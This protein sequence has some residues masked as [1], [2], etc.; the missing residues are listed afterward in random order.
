MNSNLRIF[1]NTILVFILIFSASCSRNEDGGSSQSALPGSPVKITTPIKKNLTEYITLN[2]STFFLKKEIV[3]ATFQGFVEK[4]YKNIGDKISKGDLLLEIKTKESA[5]EDNLNI[6]LGNK[7]F[8]GLITLKAQSDGVLTELDYNTGDF[9]SDGEQIAVI[10]N[11]SSLRINLGV[12]YQYSNKI[13][14]STPCEII[15]P[16]GNIINASISKIIP[17]VDPVSQTQTFILQTSQ[18]V[19]LPENLNVTVRIPIRTVKDAVV[20]PQSSVMT[21]ETLDRSWIME[22]INDTTATKVDVKTGIEND[23]LVQIIKPDINMDAKIIYD[24]A[25]G[26]PDSAKVSVVK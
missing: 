9:V 12:P 1:L 14:M 6:P 20:V 26:L 2:A 13:N 15:L 23:S 24:G 11:P 18:Y 22:L 19:N 7:T 5:A 10:S 3:R 17:K 16:N 25:Y 21:N 4:I 8:N